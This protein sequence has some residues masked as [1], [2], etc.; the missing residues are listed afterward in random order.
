MRS[1]VSVADES[2]SQ[3]L[4]KQIYR[5]LNHHADEGLRERT[6]AMCQIPTY[7]TSVAKGTEKVNSTCNLDEA[8]TVQLTKP[9][10]SSRCGLGRH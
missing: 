1:E 3:S 9:G 10:S 8:S 7:V 6:P 4:S 2:V 5:A